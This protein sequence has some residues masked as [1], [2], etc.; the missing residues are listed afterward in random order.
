MFE[1]NCGL[2]TLIRKFYKEA[3]GYDF[4]YVSKVESSFLSKVVCSVKT[5]VIPT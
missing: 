5:G 3:Q 2:V 4:A 1:C